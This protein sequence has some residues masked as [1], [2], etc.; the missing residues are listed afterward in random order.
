MPRGTSVK[1]SRSKKIEKGR[2][3]RL[4]DREREKEIATYYIISF[5][6]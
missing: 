6:K 4:K 2:E 1:C 5:T 3:H